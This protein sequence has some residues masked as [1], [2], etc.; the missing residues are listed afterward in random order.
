MQRLLA[1]ALLASAIAAPAAAGPPIVSTDDFA[2]VSVSPVGPA[3]RPAVLTLRL[4]YEMLCAQPGS[5][6]VTVSFPLALRI[7]ATIPPAAVLVDGAAP[8]SVHTDGHVVTIGLAPN[9][10]VICQSFVPGTLRIVF[11][12]SARLGNPAR[13]GAYVVRARVGTHAFA[14]TLRIRG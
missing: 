10:K 12:R 3:A 8:P 6:P 2:T 14:A 9:A 7:P 1:L 4:H 13:S 5:G 11:T